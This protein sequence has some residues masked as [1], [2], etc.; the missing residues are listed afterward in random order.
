MENEK[1][2]IGRPSAYKPEYC[3]M[4]IN[5]MAEGRS[6]ESFAGVVGVCFKTVYNWQKEYPD[7]LQA[8]KTGN[9]KRFD[10]FEKV[11]LEGLHT[12]R[13]TDGEGGSYSKAI[14]AA[15]YKLFM[16]NLFGWTDKKEV[17]E[18]TTVN[19]GEGTSKQKQQALKKINEWHARL[20]DD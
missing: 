7:F 13:E 11:G 10:Y 6:I 14:N 17:K 9:A 16:A 2:P 20:S 4:L 8:F 15:V 3:D 18:E 12:I 1:R 5:H 19:V